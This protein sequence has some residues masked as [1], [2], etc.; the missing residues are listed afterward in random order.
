MGHFI[1]KPFESL[2]GY[3]QVLPGAFSGYRWEALK[4]DKDNESILDDYLSS[5][6]DKDQE[7]TLE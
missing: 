4:R 6:L 2:F 3:I 7:L 5:V 1:D